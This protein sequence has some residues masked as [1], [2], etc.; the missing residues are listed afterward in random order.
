DELAGVLRR[1]GGVFLAPVAIL[2]GDLVALESGGLNFSG[3]RFGDQ[4]RVGEFGRRGALARRRKQIDE[5][6]D[7]Q[8]D[9][10]PNDD[11][12]QVVLIAVHGL[13][14]TAS[15]RC[16]GGGAFEAPEFHQI[17]AIGGFRQRKSYTRGG[18]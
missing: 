5:R 14:S 16:Q 2:A 18:S 3:R 13:L 11:V 8:P 4:L 7:E 15:V 9:D 10:D 17:R 6:Q 1:L 12:T